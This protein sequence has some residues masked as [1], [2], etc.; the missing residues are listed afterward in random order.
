MKLFTCYDR[1]EDS[2]EVNVGPSKVE[3]VGYVPPNILIENMIYAGMRLNA[4]RTEAYDAETAAEAAEMPIDPTRNPGFDMA[5]ASQRL[6]SLKD[7]LN[8]QKQL[9]ELEQA[10]KILA[11]EEEKKQFKLWQ[12]EQLEKKEND[13][14]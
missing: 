4:A 14:K 5:D 13:K 6:M 7:R 3:K 11:E 12:E 8:K 9:Y 10:K 2:F 1:P